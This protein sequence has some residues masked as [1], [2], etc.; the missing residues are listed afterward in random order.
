MSIRWPYG[1]F[2]ACVWVGCVCA[3]GAEIKAGWLRYRKVDGWMLRYTIRVDD[4]VQWGGNERHQQVWEESLALAF[5]LTKASGLTSARP[6]WTGTGQADVS[7]YRYHKSASADGKS[8]YSLRVGAG[9]VA[10][11][12]ILTID[13]EKGVYDVWVNTEQG[14]PVH[15]VD[16]SEDRTRAPIDSVRDYPAGKNGESPTLLWMNNWKKESLP[17]GAPTADKGLKLSGGRDFP[18]D[19]WMA[20]HPKTD[21]EKNHITYPHEG[22]YQWQLVP[23]GE[24]LLEVVVEAKDYETWTPAATMDEKHA[25]RFMDVEARLQRLDGKPPTHKAKRFVFELERVSNEPGVCLNWPPAGRAVDTP[26]LAFEKGV[27]G[28]PVIEGDKGERARTADGEYVASAVKV[29]C[30]D[31]GAFGQLKVTAEMDDGERV[32]GHLVGRPEQTRLLIP[33]REAGS[34]IATSWRASAGAAGLADDDDSER[35]PAAGKQAGDG[36]TVYEESRGFCEN[37]KHVN[38]DP[39]KVDFFVRNAVGGDAAPGIDLFA[40]LTGAEVHDRLRGDEFDKAKRVMNVNHGRG[41]HAVDQHGVYIFTEAGLNGA[42]TRFSKKGLRGRPVI[43]LGIAVQPRDA[44]TSTFSSENVPVSDAV[45]AYD[46]AIAHELMHAVGGEHHGRGDYHTSFFLK[47]ADDPENTTGKAYFTGVGGA[48]VYTVTDEATGRDLAAM[49]E[50]DLLLARERFRE[51]CFP[52]M[53]ASVAAYAKGREGTG[54]QLNADQVAEVLYN[55]MFGHFYWY[56]GAMGGECSGDEGCVMRYSFAQAYEK[57]GVPRAYYFIGRKHTERLGLE[58]C[59]AALG[60]GVNDPG[61]QP[62]PRYGDAAKGW[63]PCVER[64]IFNDAVP[65]EKEP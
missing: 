49:L 35:L 27:C 23:I 63:G 11:K 51:A 64:I 19:E 20:A 2:G 8:G 41:A 58:L 48:P 36:F 61:R 62:Q 12:A 9:K 47:F 42:E 34:N 43:T 3:R 57:R 33:R 30:F 1:F 5:P 6:N 56:V 24:E 7:L 45:F 38:G 59:R 29:S 16:H 37:G 17:E 53:K 39:K 14:W 15:K 50:P 60:T 22:S 52:Q 18:I 10:A 25:G 65:L 32:V 4:Q 40:R 44:T 28:L 31:W 13:L 55:Q 54:G 21:R 46:R 26:D